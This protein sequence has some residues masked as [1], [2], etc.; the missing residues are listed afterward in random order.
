MIYYIE[1]LTK[2]KELNKKKEYYEKNKDLIN[3]KHKEYYENNKYLI[4]ENNKETII[5]ECGCEIT[6]INLK[7]HLQSKKHLSFQ[8]N[9][10]S[11]V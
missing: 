1:L 4:K 2:I 11:T 3:E 8:T 9:I 10:S 7:R 6:K 5:C